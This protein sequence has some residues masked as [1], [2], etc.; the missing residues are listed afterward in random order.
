M[1]N[2]D[3]KMA[4]NAEYQKFALEM[5]HIYTELS[6]L[7]DYEAKQELEEAQ[8][9]WSVFAEKHA[10]FLAGLM[11]GGTG[12]S[13]LYLEAMNSLMHARISA[14]REALSERSV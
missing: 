7:L 2:N 6:A 14:L 1:S 3:L 12:E 10:R 13:L 11:R 5:R 8:N 9:A 4:A